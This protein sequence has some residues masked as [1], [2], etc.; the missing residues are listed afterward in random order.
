MYSIKANIQVTHYVLN[1][2]LQYTSKSLY[3]QSRPTIYMYSIKAYYIQVNH[4][5]LNQGLKYTSK[6]LC[7]QSRTTICK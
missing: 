5:E 6:S 3:T 7:T 2:G 1:Q 4:Y